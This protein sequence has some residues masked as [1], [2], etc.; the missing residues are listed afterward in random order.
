MK[1]IKGRKRFVKRRKFGYSLSLSKK[2]WKED[3]FTNCSIK[4]N[5]GDRFIVRRKIT[6][7]WRVLL[8]DFEK[9]QRTVAYGQTI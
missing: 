1:N 2:G 5:W 7:L 9:N 6:V 8:I 3:Y 4:R